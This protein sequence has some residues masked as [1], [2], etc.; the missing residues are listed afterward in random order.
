MMLTDI[1]PT[2]LHRVRDAA[3]YVHDLAQLGLDLLCPCEDGHGRW[4][5]A[6]ETG[7]ALPPL[8]ACVCWLPVDVFDTGLECPAHPEPAAPL[9]PV[10]PLNLGPRRSLVR[11]D[12]GPA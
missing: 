8:P 9:A 2:L 10:E 5:T 1:P 12:R 7:G 11:L 3:A 6:D 4:L